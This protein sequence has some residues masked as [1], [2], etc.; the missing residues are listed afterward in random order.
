[1]EA[2][3]LRDTRPDER[4]PPAPA[5]A[6]LRAGLGTGRALRCKACGRRITDDAAR[7]EVHGAHEHRCENPHGYRYRV[8][9]FAVAEGLDPW[10]NASTYWSWFPGYA[11]QVQ[12]CA[13]CQTLLGWLFTSADARFYGLILDAL[14]PFDEPG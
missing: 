10:G 4:Q 9:C 2:S 5:K 12:H 3:E 1:V 6:P 8:G 7:I 14:V 13:S 11:W